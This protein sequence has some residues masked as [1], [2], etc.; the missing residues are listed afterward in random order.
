MVQAC[1]KRGDSVLALGYECMS[2]AVVSAADRLLSLFR[3]RIQTENFGFDLML[4]GIGYLLNRTSRLLT[5]S[6]WPGKPV[7]QGAQT[8]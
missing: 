4:M 8:V 7:L 6:R 2:W 3:D 5:G 1:G